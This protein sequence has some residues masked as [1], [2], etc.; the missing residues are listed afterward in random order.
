MLYWQDALKYSMM[1]G[2]GVWSG[3][4]DMVEGMTQHFN[5]EEGDILAVCWGQGYSPVCTCTTLYIK[6]N[7][8]LV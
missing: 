6:L 5:L 2:Q 4:T 1:P 8:L 3:P 7:N